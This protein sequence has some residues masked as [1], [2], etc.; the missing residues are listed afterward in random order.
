MRSFVTRER[1]M[2]HRVVFVQ[3]TLLMISNAQENKNSRKS[4]PSININHK[5]ET[6]AM[7]FSTLINNH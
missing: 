5:D 1:I 7:N 6:N 2:E 3:I 4:R